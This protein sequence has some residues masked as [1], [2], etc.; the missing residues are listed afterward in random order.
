[1]GDRGTH[2]LNDVGASVS[3]ALRGHKSSLYEGGVA[4]PMI[5]HWPDGIG[6]PGKVSQQVGHVWDI[7]PTA[8]ELAG[9]EYPSG[10]DGTNCTRSMAKA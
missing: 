1:M 7:F 8:L 5:F 4:T 9:V 10:F 6:T 2:S 3:D